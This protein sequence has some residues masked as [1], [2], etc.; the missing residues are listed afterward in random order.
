MTQL[1]GQ[2]RRPL[3]D[4]FLA[5]PEASPA[6]THALADTFWVWNTLP[7]DELHQRLLQLHEWVHGV[8]P[9]VLL[10]GS[11]AATSAQRRAHANASIGNPGWTA[12]IRASAIAT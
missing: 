10:S 6:M 2:I 12:R 11:H 4:G 8:F 3:L 7:V 1:P 9:S 5:I